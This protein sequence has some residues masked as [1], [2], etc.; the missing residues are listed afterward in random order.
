[1]LVKKSKKLNIIFYYTPKNKYNLR[2]LL[3]SIELNS[4]LRKNTKILFAYN[5]HS[6]HR[7][8][9]T[10]S[11]EEKTLLCVSLFSTQEEELKKL[12]HIRKENLF[13]ICGGPLATFNPQKILQHNFD[14][15]FSGEGEE[16]FPIFL[17]HLLFNQHPL[18]IGGISY[19][20]NGAFVKYN[21]HSVIDINKYPPVSF[22]YRKFGPIELTRGCKY[23]CLFCSTPALFKHKVRHRESS[24]IIESIKRMV[25]YGYN[26]IRFITP[27]ALGYMAK[28]NKPNIAAIENLLL[29]TKKHVGKEGKIFFGS[30]PSEVRPEFVN[31]EV[32]KVLKNFV[33]ND[34]IVIG[35]QSGSNTTLKKIQR[36]HTKEDV[37]KA[38]TYIKEAGFKPY[39]D[40]ILGLPNQ[41]EEEIMED[42]E[43]I[44]HI[45]KL[46]ARPHIHYFLP[47]AGSK[48]ANSHP[49]PLN[50]YVFK[51]LNKWEAEGKIF[52]SWRSQMKIAMNIQ[53]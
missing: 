7:I 44:K 36:C 42:M 34:N 24:I 6:L 18:N 15:A 41:K 27:N 52:G 22:V 14:F 1:M 16:N 47:L 12:S 37:L 11:N 23:N 48:L 13:K 40:F 28:D 49:Q 45:I 31:K 17:K 10:I 39:I 4:Y 53:K 33:N 5:N 26:H 9:N 38:M 43:F 20:H 19:L 3:T 21:N 25:R 50:K 46:G 2:A 29:N 35:A 8:I 30:F 32:M 51:L